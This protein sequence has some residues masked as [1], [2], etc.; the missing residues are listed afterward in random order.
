MKTNILISFIIATR[1]RK[2]DLKKCLQSIYDQNY[3][4]IEIIVVDNDSSDSSFNMVSCG[5]PEVKLINLDR[6]IGCPG[7]RNI[8]FLNSSGDILFFLDDDSKISKNAALNVINLFSEDKKL[9]II[10]PKIIEDGFARNPP[11]INKKTNINRY[12]PFFSGIS[13]IRRTVFENV[14]L[15]P[16]EFLYGV[17]ENDLSIRLLNAGGRIL[18]SPDVVVSHFPASDRNINFET[19]QRIENGIIFLWK[20][21]PITRAILGT[22]SRLFYSF[23]ASVKSKSISGWLKAVL[24]FPKIIL[25]TILNNRSQLGWYPFRLQEI[26]QNNIITSWEQIDE[27]KNN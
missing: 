23:P 12:I 14:G 18:Y 13:A 16:I 3:K 27:H 5:F 2:N 7:G 6:N 24:R 10:S 20:Y 26:F 15:F 22:I 1:D 9:S 17:E 8:G 11:G 4:N 21:A 19:Q 25:T